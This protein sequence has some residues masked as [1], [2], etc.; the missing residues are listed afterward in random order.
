VPNLHIVIT[1]S[2]LPDTSIEEAVLAPLDAS[3][4]VGQCRTEDEVLAIGR[5]ADAL[6]VQFAPITRRVIEQLTRCK[7]ISRFGVG[8]DMV[9]LDAAREHGIPVKNVPD[10]C[11]EEVASHAVGFMLA[12]GRKLFLQDRLMHQG[13][14][15]LPGSTGAIERLRDQTLG[16]VGL[17]RIGRKVAEFV[18]PLG[19]RIIGFDIRPPDNFPTIAFVELNTVLRESDYLSLH[20]P[21]TAETRHLINGAALQQMKRTSF[22]INVSRGGVI[23]TT[24][25][26]E[27]LASKQIAGAALDVFE[28]EPLPPDHPL[29]KMDN[30]ILTPHSAAISSDA[31]RQL[32]HDTAWN[33]FT[34]LKP[35]A[36]AEN[37]SMGRD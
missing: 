13:L 36:Q 26:V 9:D 11:V 16:L 17:G 28:Q 32:R 1:D 27:A 3:I 12:L 23:D 22:L 7:V 5:D 14:W 33:V 6:M 30:V 24:A 35:L 4:A 21:L 20:C 31:I 8:V 34:V 15:R 19:L 25:L 18:A 29:R 2:T 37:R 10:Y